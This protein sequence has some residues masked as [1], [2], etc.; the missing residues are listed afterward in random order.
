MRIIVRFKDVRT[1]F[2]FKGFFFRVYSKNRNP[3]QRDSR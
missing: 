2:D 1:R 3:T